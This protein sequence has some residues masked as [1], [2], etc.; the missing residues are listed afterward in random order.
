MKTLIIVLLLACTSS[1]LAEVKPAPDWGKKIGT[2]K[3]G[4]LTNTVTKSYSYAAHT[5]GVYY[6]NSGDVNMGLSLTPFWNPRN[7]LYVAL[8]IAPHHV[9]PSL[10][11]NLVPG[12]DIGVGAGYL[13]N[14]EKHQ[15][16]PALTLQKRF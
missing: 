7:P 6:P 4:K 8:D 3:E 5:F 1:V 15:F 13:Y 14:T 16:E 10:N 9:G 12:I 2:F 11:L